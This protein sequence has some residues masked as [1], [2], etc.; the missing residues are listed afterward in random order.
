MTWKE[1]VSFSYKSFN[2]ICEINIMH[3]HVFV[4]TKIYPKIQIFVK[5]LIAIRHCGTPFPV[6]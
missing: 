6:R 3:V 4:W 1:K 5:C 2:F